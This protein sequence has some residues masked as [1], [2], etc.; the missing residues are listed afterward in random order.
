MPYFTLDLNKDLLVCEGSS[1]D[2]FRFKAANAFNHPSEKTF[3]VTSILSS[4][5]VN[6]YQ[7]K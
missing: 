4:F 6:N 7:S 3:D 5:L 2:S 1:L